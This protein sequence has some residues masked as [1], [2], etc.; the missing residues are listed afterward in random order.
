MKRE[1]KLTPEEER[2]ITFK[3]TEAP[4][5]GEYDVFHEPGV[6]VCKRCDAPLYLSADKFTSGCG[7]PSFD[8]E[9]AN[10]VVKVEDADGERVEILCKNCGAHLGHVFKGERFTPKNTRHCVNSISLRFIPAFTEQG[11]ERAIFAGG[12]FWGVEHLLK[13][14][15]GVVKTTVGYTGGFV[16]DPT[17]EEVCSGKTGHTEAL[18]VIF[19]PEDTNFEVVAKVFFEIHDPTQKSRQ[20]PD[21]GP[22]YR[23]AIFFLT[24]A[25]R[26]AA[27]RLMKF[28]RDQ[29]L[30]V[31]TELLP[32]GP[33]YPAEDYH[34]RYYDK[35]GKQPYCH[36]RVPR[37]P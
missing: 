6:Y 3:G 12:C 37:F 17:Y 8:D 36:T 29:G 33:F 15:P 5:S 26:R 35:T 24:E 1:H 2:V 4:G 20:G 16:T 23:S 32:A 13:K 25:Q 27:L 18:E 34:Q 9:I 19:D 14:L 28:L 22:Q 11:Y 10:A 30:N 31:V 7:W 21:I